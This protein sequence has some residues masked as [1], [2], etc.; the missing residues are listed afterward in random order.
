MAGF[1][2]RLRFHLSGGIIKTSKYEA[3]RVALEKKYAK[4]TSLKQAA[5]LLRYRELAVQV[6]TPR[7]QSGLSK[8]KWLA[9]KRELTQLRKS[10]DVSDFFKLQK[11]SDNFLEIL[12]WELVFEDTF[13]GTALDTAK[14]TPRPVVIEAAPEILY[15]PFGENHLYTDGANVTVSGHALKISVRREQASGIGFHEQMGFLPIA[16]SYTSGIISTAQSHLQQYGKVEAKIRFTKLEKGMYYAMWLGTGKKLPHVNVL[17]IGAE[18]ELSAFAEKSDGEKLQH[19]EKWRRSLL[20]Q[21]TAYIVAIEW[22]KEVMI[23]KINGVTLFSA[24]N[25]VNEPMYIAFSSG[26]MGKPNVSTLAALEVCWVRGYKPHD[27]TPA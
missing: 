19:V 18:V 11:S 22:S 13:G 15:S 4:Y 6:A 3:Q 14:W 5:G 7:R 17:R 26:V 2:K 9:M 1:F 10:A 25:V 21:N 24:P 16:R 20:R 23:W 12:R 27:A 8:K